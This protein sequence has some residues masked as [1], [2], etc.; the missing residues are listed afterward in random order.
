MLDVLVDVMEQFYTK[1]CNRFV[2]ALHEEEQFD[3]GGF[4]VGKNTV[5]SLT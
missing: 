3:A 5:F 4:P 2:E 1:F